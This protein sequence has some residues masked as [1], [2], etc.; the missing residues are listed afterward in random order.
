MATHQGALLVWGDVR[1]VRVLFH[2]T[3]CCSAFILVLFRVVS[4]AIILLTTSLSY[5][6]PRGRIESIGPDR[7]DGQVIG[8]GQDRC[9]VFRTL[10]N[11][12]YGHASCQSS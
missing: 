10:H 8:S 6:G 4:C 12:H 5:G 9:V 11:N 2:Y 7:R 3:M 1:L